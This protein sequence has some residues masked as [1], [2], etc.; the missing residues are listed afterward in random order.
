[1][2]HQRA[3]H[4]HRADAVAGDV[5]HVVDAAEDPEV[6]VLIALGAVAREVQVLPFTP[7]DV[8]VALV[9]APDGARHAGPRRRDGEIA[10]ADLD[11]LAFAVQQVGVDAGEGNRPRAGLGDG[12]AGQRRDHDAARLRLPPRIHDG[13][14]LPADVLVIPHPR[15][16]I[17]RLADAAEQPQ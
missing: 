15:F 11:A 13:A 3:L 1:M 6:A 9:V 8:T 10:A 17:D 7:V 12:D 16:R 14:A 2:V 4:F 5:E